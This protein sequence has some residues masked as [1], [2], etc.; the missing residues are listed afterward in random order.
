MDCFISFA[1]VICHL[2]MLK[3]TESARLLINISSIKQAP[4]ASGPWKGTLNASDYG[5]ACIQTSAGGST[6]PQSEDC[7]FLNVFVPSTQVCNCKMSKIPV[8]IY[9]FGGAF[10]A[11]SGDDDG[12][13]LLLNRCVIVVM[14]NYRVGVFGF[15]PLGLK[16]Y[17]GNM[18]LKDQQLAM[19]WVK[20]HIPAFGG[21]KNRILLFGDSVGRRTN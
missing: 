5:A 4:V 17:S 1:R 10:T 16:E 21:D 20:D 6:S 11:G 9:I 14:F 2:R 12:P 7:L 18:A 8:I 15:L 13:E 19:R 3:K